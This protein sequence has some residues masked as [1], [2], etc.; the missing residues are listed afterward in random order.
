MNLDDLCAYYQCE[1]FHLRVAGIRQKLEISQKQL[2][3]YVCV[4]Q[5][6]ISRLEA[7]AD[8]RLSTWVKVLGGLSL[9]LTIVADGPGDEEL[10]DHWVERKRRKGKHEGGLVQYR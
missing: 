8:A 3:D 2:A 4:P 9:R 7:G 6:L 10:D 1:P 5:S